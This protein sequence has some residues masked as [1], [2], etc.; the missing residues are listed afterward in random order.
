LIVTE[1]EIDQSIA[2]LERACAGLA[3]VKQAAAQ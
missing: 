2:S 1:A 3:S